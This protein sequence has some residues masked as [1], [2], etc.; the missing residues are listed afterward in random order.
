MMQSVEEMIQKRFDERDRVIG[1]AQKAGIMIVSGKD[2]QALRDQAKRDL[3]RPPV[4]PPV[5]PLPKKDKP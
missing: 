2:A 1:A 3:A 5:K 4:K